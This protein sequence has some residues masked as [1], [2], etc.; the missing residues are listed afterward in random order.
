MSS[1]MRW[2]SSTLFVLIAA[3]PA[4]ADSAPTTL[5]MRSKTA[6]YHH[7]H[8]RAVGQATPDQPPDQP[9]APPPD[10]PPPPP[11]DQPPPPPPPTPNTPPPP[12]TG[13]T[14]QTPNLTDE[15]LQKLAEQEGKEEVIVV[16]GSTIERKTLT[17]PAPVTVVNKQDLDAAGRTTVG[18]ILQQL[19]SATNGINAQVNN[20]GDG[21][22]R[23]DLRGLGPQRTL[24]LLNGRRI[25]SGGTGAD[26]SPDLNAIPLAVIE[27]VEVLK[28]GASAVYGSDAISGVVNIIT[29]RDF[30]GTEATVYT[31]V[32]ENQGCNTGVKADGITPVDP[33]C[34]GKDFTGNGFNYDASF[35]TGHNSKKGNI[36]FSAGF[37][38]QYPVF[39]GDRPWSNQAL[40]F[41]FECDRT[42]ANT[43][44]PGLAPCT[45]PGGSSAAPGGRIDPSSILNP[46]TGMPTLTTG[47]CDPDPTVPCTNNGKG[48]LRPFGANDLYNFAS[49]NYLY[50]PSRR[51][52]L[53]TAGHYDL[54]KNVDVF[55]EGLYLNRTSDQQ[56][57][58]E[59]F[60]A[61]V[62]IT[63]G[64]NP[65]GSLI[66]MYNPYNSGTV[67]QEEDI[68]DYR[69]R[70]VE[71]GPREF[72]ENVDTFRIVTGLEGKL[73]E[74]LPVFKDWKWEFSYN[75]G[76]TE[77]TLIN[78]GNL[79]LS[80]LANAVGPS[81]N[82]PTNGPTCGTPTAP[83]TD[84]CI[85]MNI[86][87]PAGS[88]DPAAV[89]YVT[90]T[91]V[92]HGFNEQR[93]TMGTAHGELAKTPW[94]GDI[95]A[96]LGGDYRRESGGF[97]PEPLAAIGDTTNPAVAPTNG[98]YNVVEGYGE[99]SIV[100]VANK[101]FAEWT[102]IDLAAR[103][104]HYTIADNSLNNFSYKVGG[105]F[106]TAGGL[107]ARA[108]YSTAFR[109]PNVGELFG[110]TSDN[111]PNVE[112]P[113]DINKP[114]QGG[115][116]APLMGNFAKNCASPAIGNVTGA[117]VVDPNTGMPGG[118]FNTG[119]QKER[120]G[121][122]PLLQPETANTLT[123]GLV[124]E[125]KKGLAFTADYWAINIDNVIASLGSNVILNNCYGLSTPI[126]G[127]SGCG[128]IHR[129]PLLGGAIDHIDDELA[130]VA[131]LQ[132]DGIDISASY[133]F[134]DKA[135]GHIRTSGDLTWLH[136]YDFLPTGVDVGCTATSTDPN[137]CQAIHGKGN[138]DEGLF[139][140]FRATASALWTGN[141]GFGAGLIFHY[142]GTYH[143]CEGG[144]C[145]T[146]PIDAATG[147]GAP[148]RDVDR[149][150]LFSLFGTYSV[151]SSQGT[152]TITVGINNL[153]NT[154]P[155]FVYTAFANNTDGSVYDFFGRYYYV[156][157]TQLF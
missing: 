150:Y 7:K 67:G 64:L 20:G 95:S 72:I 119:Q 126:L 101:K 128:A 143:E 34:G 116:I 146:V 8:S 133:D 15:E 47:L 99:L 75:Y 77:A 37:Q 78:K 121:G 157:L 66:N 127:S 104:V 129:N 90:Y 87:G 11:P 73:P 54:G 144:V 19:P 97:D 154:D 21:S 110:G 152:T 92:S 79:I 125:P 45:A 93:T 65:D 63:G 91:G 12:T 102:E 81:F 141:A 82:D 55:F 145:S 62:P 18:D 17:T 85:P 153:F 149:Y 48:G 58:P 103:E 71:F 117:T 135:I 108:S 109:A 111:F 115:V 27:R 156:R 113:C 123:A 147:Q 50:T 14:E 31:G 74:D 53:F 139:P 130:N 86:L 155:P 28:D 16:T 25:V 137:N 96:A 5:R 124:W 84:G 100:P 151:K 39:D 52:N 32:A 83:L 105:L 23:I 10:Q 51:Y 35:V 138:F 57:A 136:K 88:I 2:L 70:L 61:A 142:V 60:L 69:R 131:K 22:T 29:R 68:F 33:N 132:T 148:F 40:A 59:P 24:T 42:K 76:R 49:V 38:R 3:G 112:D 46:N 107:A 122:N 30:D 13:G 140:A 9:P 44:F 106:R 4:L 114:S 89:N 26:P 134:S 98:S 41:D 80:H 6:G 118:N 1:S 120:V 56:L 43:D 94:G 36:I